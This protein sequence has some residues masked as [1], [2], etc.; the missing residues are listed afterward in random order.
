[1][2]FKKLRRDYQLLKAFQGVFCD[3]KK[4][5]KPEAKIVLAFLRD[6]AGARGELGKG[7]MPYFYDAHNKFDTGAAVFLLGKR[8][9]FDLIIK[10]LALDEVEVFHLC[11]QL[12]RDEGVVKQELEI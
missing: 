8:R 2:F 1:M 6:E 9:M 7:T 11:G 4:Q 10:Y 5:L 3:D 12:M